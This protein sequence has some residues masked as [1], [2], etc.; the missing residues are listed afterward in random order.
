MR[1]VFVGLSVPRFAVDGSVPSASAVGA[2]PL[3]SDAKAP[4]LSGLDF[5]PLSVHESHVLLP[6]LIVRAF[7]PVPTGREDYYALC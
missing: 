7:A 6:L 3:L 1:A 2:S 4:D 5:P